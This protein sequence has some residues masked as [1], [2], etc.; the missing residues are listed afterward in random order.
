MRLNVRVAGDRLKVAGAATLLLIAGILLYAGGHWPAKAPASATS[1]GQADGRSGGQPQQTASIA[2]Q[3]VS[4]L[5]LSKIPLS[6]EANQGQTEESVKFLA[7]GAGYTLFL[8]QKAA[9]LKLSSVGGRRLARSHSEHST[10]H[11][12]AT[13]SA[14]R[15]ELVG[16]RTHA[17][18]TGSE[19]LPGR[20]N[21]FLGNDRSKWRRDLPQFA[22]VRYE[23]VY[24]GI[25]LVFYGN[26]GRLEYDFE[27]APGADP[28]QIG[29]RVDGA[30]KLLLSPKGA[31]M[32]ETDA[33]TIQLHAPEIYQKFGNRKRAVPGKFVLGA[34]N[35]VRIAL[36][37][38]DRKRELV[39]D[40][41]LTFAAYFGG[42]ADE[43][44]A[45]TTGTYTNPVPGC[46]SV[47]VDGALNWYVA[48]TTTS[49]NLQPLAN[50]TSLN[51]SG[52]DVFI[53]KFNS[54]GTPV[55]VTYLGG[56]GSDTPV[57]VGVDTASQRVYVGGNT[58]SADFPV[59]NGIP[60]GTLSAG[61]HAFVTVFDTSLTAPSYSSYLAGTGTADTA[62]AF[63]ND[64]AGNAYLTGITNSSD[65]PTTPGSYQATDPDAAFSQFFV[66]K[67]ATSST[68]LNSLAYSTY[69]GAS[70]APASGAVLQGGGIA[71]S[72]G[73]VYITGATNF[74]HTGVAGDFPILSAFQPCL[75][76]PG[77][78]S[79]CPASVTNTDAFV[80]KINPVTSGSQLVYSTYL[81][82]SGVDVP[83]GIAVDSSGNAFVTGSTDS[84]DFI[85]PSGTT[86]F[87]ATNRGGGDA[88]VA[89][90]A[91]AGTTLSYFSYLGG[92]AADAAYGI[93]V[94][95]SQAAHITGVTTSPDLT[96]VDVITGTGPG[97]GA[98]AFVALLQTT[99]AGTTGGYSSYLESSG[100][101]G[102]T[103]ATG[104][105]VDLNGNT[106]VVGET[107]SS[108]FPA[109]SGSLSGGSD[110]FLAKISPAAT[111]IS[112][113][114][115]T[116]VASGNTIGIGNQ[117]T[118]TYTIKNAGPGVAT[119]VLFTDFLPTTG[120]TFASATSTPGSC[121]A[122]VNG[123]VTCAVGSLGG[124]ASSPGQATIKINLTPT[125]AGTLTNNGTLQANGAPAGASSA[126]VT[127]SDFSVGVTPAT[128]AV[129]A[130]NTATY[131][132]QVG[133][134]NGQTNFFPNS[135]SLSC[136]A[137]VPTGAACTFSTNPLTM[138]ST[139]A[140]SSTLTLTTTA[141]PVTT[142][143]VRRFRTWY[144]A[145]VPIGGFTLL[146]LGAGSARRRRWILAM[147][148][149][150]LFGLVGLQ[151]A[152]SSGSGTTTPP[153]GTPAGTYPITVTGTSGSASHAV[154]MTL[155]VQ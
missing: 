68:G 95:V 80:A 17:A 65:F 151:L 81:G 150:L 19:L 144:A 20:S 44:C 82:G 53:A 49:S 42:S 33:G 50:G 109:T 48:G 52:P 132:V 56:S 128:A 105:A 41:Q 98:S 115:T 120:A 14:V 24:P 12:A 146:G 142:G 83:H 133:V 7:R 79:N 148:V 88:F 59:L 4:R 16:A 152:C 45:F 64:N 63:T 8:T 61:N 111:G 85:I 113:T 3:P 139:S 62:T 92:T 29:L 141:R 46:P 25:N 30:E 103:D 39:I 47:A 118:F 37:E 26:Q 140:I 108:G 60:T 99:F 2:P 77:I 40:P 155:I 112:I 11:S 13:I 31:L 123:S 10:Q 136:S 84:T 18:V 100:A 58:T 55:A 124:S 96:G 121:T 102:N 54:S 43:G 51:G 107:S 22:R 21:Y 27:V 101:N 9:L 86:P 93:A 126:N 131:Q 130:G 119:N 127:V 135:V 97:S 69:F 36:G 57:G 145:L 90:I 122:A 125:V 138:T 70:H 94:D 147:F 75:D 91:P 149:T 134:P 23:Q 78:T 117:V 72:G 73:A 34:D 35:K 76:A 143:A 114:P 1:P 15:M 67:I 6:F 137:G 104:I 110:A 28:N 129:A 71:V 154:R 89:K 153:A 74:L 5:E 87:Q 116:S 38:Y 66:S 106:Y 32:A